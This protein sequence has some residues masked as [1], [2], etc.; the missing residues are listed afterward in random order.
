MREAFYQ[1]WRI[2]SQYCVVSNF[3]ISSFFFVSAKENCA[4]R[5]FYFLLNMGLNKKAN[6]PAT[7]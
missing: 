2:F 1:Y 4:F 3:D 6:L 5:D 7:H